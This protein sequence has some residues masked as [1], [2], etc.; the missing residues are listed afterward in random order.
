MAKQHLL[1]TQYCV[2]CKSRRPIKGFNIGRALCAEC[3][4]SRAVDSLRRVAGKKAG[5]KKTSAKLV[6]P[7][8]WKC[9]NCL[10]RIDVRL[11]TELADHFNAQGKPCRGSGY[12]LP[13]KRL[14]ALD[15]RASGSFE[16][17]RRR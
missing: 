7:K 14:D 6:G 13:Q 2:S 15:H 11:G 1:L 8:T 17:G 16:N 12:Q 3:D 5:R 4:A 10:R 9:P